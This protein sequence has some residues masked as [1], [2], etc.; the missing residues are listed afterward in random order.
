MNAKFWSLAAVFAMGTA[1]LDDKAEEEE[2]ESEPTSEPT[3]E[4][5]VSEPSVPDEPVTVWVTQS[6]SGSAVVT[7]GESYEG[8]ETFMVGEND[9]AG[10]APQTEWI[11]NGVGIP[12]D[13]PSDCQDCVFAFDLNMTFD[14]AAST[15]PDGAGEDA[16]F[17]Y[18]FGTSSYGENTL[19]YGTDGEWSTFLVDGDP[20]GPDSDGTTFT[21]S[22]AFDGTKVMPIQF[23]SMRE[24]KDYKDRWDGVSGADNTLYG[25]SNFISQFIQDKFPD[26]I[27]YNRDMINVSTIDIEVYSDEGF[28]KPEEA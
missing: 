25:N 21:T 12:M 18:A 11:W 14:A 17:S 15:D 3:S 19:F 20:T 5:S 7:P 6:W 9:S 22:V 4:P 23:H 27:E 24:V 2:E 8:I 16:V 1:C 10:Q 28:P 13:N 26:D